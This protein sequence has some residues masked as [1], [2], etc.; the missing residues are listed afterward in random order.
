[1]KVTEANRLLEITVQL[2]EHAVGAG[3][4]VLLEN[5]ARSRLWLMPE[6]KRIMRLPRCETVHVDYCQYDDLPWRKSTKFVTWNMTGLRLRRCGNGGICTRT[7][8]PHAEL[9]G[10]VGNIFRTKTA[11]PYPPTM[12][13]EIAK[14]TTNLLLHN[15]KIRIKI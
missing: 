3:I 9:V 8:L 2:I 5:P 11:E 12:C 1:M 4:M 7:G 15:W 10:K 14:Y 13:Q 6:V